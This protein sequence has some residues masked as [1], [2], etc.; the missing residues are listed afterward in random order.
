MLITDLLPEVNVENYTSE[1]KA[2]LLTGVDKHKE[3]NE[4]K[5]LKEIVAFSNTQGGTV[6]V[7]VNDT[8]HELEPLSHQEI[9]RTVQLVY[10]KIEERIEPSIQIEV[11]EIPLGKEK[12]DQYILRIDVKKSKHTPVYVHVNGVPACY[13]RQFGRAKIASPEQIADLVI[14]STRISYDDVFTEQRYQEC[15]F[16][17]FKERFLKANPGKEFNLKFLQSIGFID[18][19]NRLSKGALLFQDSCDSPLT[20]AKCSCFPTFTKGGDVVTASLSFQGCLF[21]V[22]YSVTEFVKNHSTTGYQKTPNSRIDLSSF[23]QRA[24]FEG[25]VNAFAHRNYFISGTEVQI[26]IFPDRLEITSPG[27]LLGGKN[28]EKEKN[29]TS[30]IPKRRNEVICKVFESVHEMEAKGTGFDKISQDYE[31]AEEAKQPFI[32]CSDDFFTLTLPDM[33]FHG[34]VIGD[35]NP[36]PDIH[37]PREVASPYDEKILSCCYIKKRSLTEIASFLNISASSHL[38]KDILGKLVEEG[39]LFMKQYGKAFYYLSNKEKLNQIKAI[40]KD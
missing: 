8:S 21:D 31:L 23:P 40:K 39:Y 35:D 38:R 15:E 13:I 16:T 22:I 4:L 26:D 27:S 33:T 7:G 17:K 37:L 19:E 30:I 5:W 24:V 12:P 20:L 36:Y 11:K 25:V 29:I 18:S 28:L 3:D 34:G 14:Q 32:S 2:R 10:Q 6:Y 1:F 9:D